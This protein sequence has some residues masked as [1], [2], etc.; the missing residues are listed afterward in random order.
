MA[1]EGQEHAVLETTVLVNFLKIDRLDLLARH[2]KYRF[3]LTNHVRGEVTS[4]YPEQLERLEL[5]VSGK[6]F[7]EEAVDALDPTFVMLT[8]EGRL[9]VG[10]CAAIA[11]AV[12][13]RLPIA[14]DDNRARKTAQRVLPAVVLEGTESV[15]VSL[16]ASGI[17]DVAAADAIKADWEANHRFTLKFGSFAEK[18]RNRE[19]ESA[20]SCLR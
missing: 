11:L 2:P 5:A 6:I 14:I 17:L 18:P 12:G 16:I 15:M 19:T 9:G 3:V 8:R 20:L 1:T 4:D 7:D 10:E 13:K